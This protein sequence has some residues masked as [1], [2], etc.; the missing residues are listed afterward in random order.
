MANSILNNQPQQTPTQPSN[1]MLQQF[2]QFKR[3]FNGNPQQAVMNMI[4]SGQRSQT[5]LQE[6]MNYA[7]QFQNLFK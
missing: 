2:Q 7:R 5:Q 6:A 4:A 1:Q 3:D